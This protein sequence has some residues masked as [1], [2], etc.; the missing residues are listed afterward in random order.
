MGLE[1]FIGRAQDEARQIALDL[2]R[3]QALLVAESFYFEGTW[4]TREHN[5]PYA[6][7]ASKDGIDIACDRLLQVMRTPDLEPQLL[8][9][10][11][12]QVKHK[13]VKT[14]YRICEGTSISIGFYAAAGMYAAIIGTESTPETFAFYQ[15]KGRLHPQC[16]KEWI[17]G[18]LEQFGQVNLGKARKS[19]PEFF[20]LLDQSIALDQEFAQ[21]APSFNQISE[22]I[23]QRLNILAEQG[24]ETLDKWDKLRHERNFGSYMQRAYQLRGLVYPRKIR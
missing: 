14:L 24:A 12:E 13:L 18:L 3:E 17:D 23:R 19:K 9:E 10:Q 21:P 7:I 1:S 22:G 2:P 11:S 5:I 8:D 4:R 20:D 15:D 16:T 6:F